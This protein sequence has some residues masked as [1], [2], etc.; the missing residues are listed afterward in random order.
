MKGGF[1][2]A[3]VR[4]N[5][6]GM[7]D[8]DYELTPPPGVYRIALLG[9]STAMAAGVEAEQ[10]FEALLEE[11]LNREAA[12]RA[13]GPFE[14]L[15]FG[16]AGY[17]PLQMLYQLDRKVFGF[18]P[19]MAM[20]VGHESDLRATSRWWARMVHTS[21]LPRNAFNDD[22]LRR[23]G[24]TADAG[25]NETRRRLRPFEPELLGW[26]YRQ[27]VAECRERG[28]TPSF[29]YLEKVTDDARSGCVAR[30]PARHQPCRQRRLHRARRVGRLRSSGQRAS[31]DCRERRPCER[32]RQSSD[33]R[34][35]V[36]AARREPRQA[37]ARSEVAVSRH[38]WGRA[39]TCRR[40]S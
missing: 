2:G 28:V 8:R 21:V 26:V 35:A 15:N 34:T 36:H 16:V 9:P 6:W 12:T 13:Q 3:M 7:R 11:R 24:L 30:A 31:R 27:F 22:L 23:S 29:V 32:G 1:V 20:F 39:T 19:D 40:C 5:R 4:T 33:R 14:I 18:D 37:R 38:F 10:S 17:S 25:P